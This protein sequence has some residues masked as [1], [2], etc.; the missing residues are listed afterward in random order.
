[1]D[2]LKLKLLD[3]EKMNKYQKTVKPDS[4]ANSDLEQKL[5]EAKKQISTLEKRRNGIK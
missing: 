4:A 3:Y 1:M 5:N 2:D